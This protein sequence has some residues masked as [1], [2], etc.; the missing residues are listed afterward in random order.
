MTP[1]TN[2]DVNSTNTAPPNPNRNVHLN[3][4]PNANLAASL[5]LSFGSVLIAVE[6]CLNRSMISA[7]SKVRLSSRLSTV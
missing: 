3:A 4:T 7:E 1:P 2:N 6:A 5:W